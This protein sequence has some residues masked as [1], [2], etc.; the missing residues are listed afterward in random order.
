MGAVGP[1]ELLLPLASSFE[2]LGGAVDGPAWFSGLVGWV[3]DEKIDASFGDDLSL[4][5]GGE[6]SKPPVNT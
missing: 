2:G 5:D 3:G 1:S 6:V 4:L